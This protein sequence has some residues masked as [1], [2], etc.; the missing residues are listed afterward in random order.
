MAIRPA[1]L[2]ATPFMAT[3]LFLGLGEAA[4]E[5]QDRESSLVV[6]V[7]GEGGDPL[8]GAQVVLRGMGMGALTDAGGAARL[9]D[10][11]SGSLT[12]EVRYLGY[13]AQ[14]V[15][16]PLEPARTTT[17]HFTLAVEP[18]KLAAV[19]VQGRRRSVLLTSGFFDRQMQGQG[20]F[21][22]R[23]DI[24]KMQP[25]QLSDVLRRVVG[26]NV[27]QGPMTGMARASLRGGRAGGCPIQYYVD[28]T[29]TTIYNPDEVLPDDVEGLEIYRGAATVPAV[30]NKGTANCGVIVIW[31]RMD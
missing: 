26:M 14:A 4:L 11:P 8:Q 29:L 30:F 6:Q 9:H 13:G 24:R 10:L 2:L 15:Q 27:R 1:P 17:V 25:M 28:G 22:T 12:V 31:T 3:F 16:L 18:I 7:R 19:T 5:A 23:E 20:T 21:I